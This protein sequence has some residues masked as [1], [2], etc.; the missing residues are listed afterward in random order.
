MSDVL[1]TENTELDEIRIYQLIS[2]A[3]IEATP[4]NWNSAFLELKYSE[5][6]ISH[7]IVSDE[8]HQEIVSA[9]EEIFLA[10]RELE[11]FLKVNQRMFSSALFRIWVNENNS[12]KYSAEFTY[13]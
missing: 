13:E 4:E 8:G 2:T 10:T 1:K 5:G 6:N 7:C 3:L 12:W 11:L 9:T